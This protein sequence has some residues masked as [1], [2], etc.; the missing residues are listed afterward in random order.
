MAATKTENLKPTKEAIKEK[1]LADLA[2]K[3]VGTKPMTFILTKDRNN[4]SFKPKCRHI[5]Q[6]NGYTYVY[7]MRYS[8]IFETPF[9][10]DQ[11]KSIIVSLDRIDFPD[12][13]WK[14][15]PE[16]KGLQ[17]FLLLHPMYGKDKVFYLE[18]KEADAVEIENKF[19]DMTTVVDLC[20]TVDFESLQAVYSLL[21]PHVSVETNVSV[22]RASI[23]EKIGNGATA[24]EIIDLFGDK[25]SKIKF[26][27]M[28]AIRYGMITVNTRNTELSWKEGGTIYS[29]APGLDVKKE[30]AEWAATT[31]DG[32]K[33]YDKILTKIN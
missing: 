13:R 31:D 16:D 2:K 22:L 11:D 27:L 14:I 24:R 10:D 15:G 29:C 5:E 30:F 21:F 3:G 6:G 12:Y 4:H 19:N 8:N 26:K 7:N 25:K 9:E 1:I 18:D 33:V 23:L 17:A 28:T 32:G 20:R